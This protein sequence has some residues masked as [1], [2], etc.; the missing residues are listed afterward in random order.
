[1]ECS[2][3]GRVRA[4][5]TINV[6]IPAGVSTGNRIHLSSQGEVGA[7][8]GPAG[9]LYVELQVFPHEI[10]RREGDDLEVVVKIP[11]TAAALGT[12]VMVAT[13]EADLED[14]PL[15]AR[16]VRITV[17]SGTQSGTRIPID[18]KGVPRLRG[19]GRGQLGVT[20]L[21]QTPTRIDDEQ[22]D[23]LRQLAELRDET[24]AEVT[25]QKHSRGVFGRLRDAFAGQ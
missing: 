19:S 12:E 5:R 20:L 17:P 7:G 9:D 22:R 13:L 1:M 10:F 16:T 8:G 3:D 14:S 25:V 18:G 15:E 11:M 6:K 2:G 4:T 24:R 21:V 23:L